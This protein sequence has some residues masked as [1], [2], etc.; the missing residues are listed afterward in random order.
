MTLEICTTFIKYSAQILGYGPSLLLW[1][2]EN[3]LEMEYIGQLIR[4]RRRKCHKLALILI[5]RLV[6]HLLRDRILLVVVQQQ[7][8]VVNQ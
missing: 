7:L 6:F 1:G 4:R 8:V 2:V 3:L 5:E